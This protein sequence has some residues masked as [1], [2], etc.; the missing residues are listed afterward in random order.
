[1]FGRGASGEPGDRQIQCAPEEVH[2]T[3]LA[4]EAGPE[5]LEDAVHLHQCEPEPVHLVAV[6]GH[7]QL[8]GVEGN[9]ALD[10]DRHR[11]DLGG[12]S[13]PVEHAHHLAVEIGDRAWAQGHCPPIPAG[14]GDD[15][16]VVDEVEVDRK[17]FVGVRNQPGGQTACRHVEHARSTSGSSAA[18][19]PAGPCRRPGSSAEGCRGCRPTGPPAVRATPRWIQT[20]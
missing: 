10:L 9:R 19:S 12:Q 5:H 3:D 8:I 4:D 7:V 17:P 14:G 15:Q 11:P 18:C 16:L 6:V 2:R 20:W 1:M 13:Q